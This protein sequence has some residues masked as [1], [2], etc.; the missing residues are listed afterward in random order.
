MKTLLSFVI[1]VSVTFMSSC[2]HSQ[3]R[4]AEK[5]AEEMLLQFYSKHFYI[6]ENTPINES[7]PVNVL[8]DRLD[9]LMQIFCTEKLRK[10][11]REA[12]YNVGADWLTN[13]LVGSVNE[14]LKVEKIANS[15]S[16]YLVSFIA[17]DED[18]SGKMAKKQVTLRVTLLKNGENYKIDGVK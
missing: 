3:N 9:S 6:W 12:F 18:A 5:Q 2:G 7:V 10:E 16:S 15:G 14:S 4:T 17:L 8:G 13:D 11:A 1:G